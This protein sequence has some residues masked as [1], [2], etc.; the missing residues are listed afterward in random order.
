MTTKNVK[1]ADARLIEDLTSIN[2]LLRS[3][4]GLAELVDIHADDDDPNTA[5][6]LAIGIK[7]LTMQAGILVDRQLQLR[8]EHWRGW[9]EDPVET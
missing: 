6:E 7:A 2:E 5:Q 3:T 8:N 9:L 4:E 1:A